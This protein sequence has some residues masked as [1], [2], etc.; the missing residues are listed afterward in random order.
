[1]G[2]GTPA[3]RNLIFAA[4]TDGTLGPA[5]NNGGPPMAVIRLGDWRGILY[6]REEKPLSSGRTR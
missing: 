1:V 2:R 3:A 6:S 4:P 5:C